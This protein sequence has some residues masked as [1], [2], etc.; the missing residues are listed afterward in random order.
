M[1]AQQ[2]RERI[3][4]E[5]RRHGGARVSDL[6]DALGV[7]DMTVR[8]D[9]A[10]LARKGLVHRV[11]GGVAATGGR[12]TDEPGF[13]AKSALQ[14]EQKAAIAR[15]AVPLVS[16]GDSVALSAGTTTL[17][18]ARELLAV[19][20]LT[21]VTNSLPV[22]DLLHQ[23]G[24]RD[25]TVVLTGGVRTPS[26]ALVGPVALGALTNL[27]VDWLFLGVHGI[28]EQAGLTTPN[29]LEAATNQAMVASARSAVVLAD[30]TKW[31]V[32]GL[33]TIVHLDQVDVLVSDDGLSADARRLLRQRVGRLVLAEDGAR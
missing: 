21:V 23:S 19:A 11:H 8:R 17:A 33:S 20:D 22:A 14:T 24:R 31:G 6:V 2:R 5:V 4:E 28:D 15:E 3:L 7:S 13:L 26:D 1:L 29:L 16:P 32:V 27:H 12:S 30:S 25:L 10:D 18:L 9:I